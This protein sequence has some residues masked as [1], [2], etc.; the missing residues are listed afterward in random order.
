MTLN[1]FKEL[2]MLDITG[3][4]SGQQYSIILLTWLLKRVNNTKANLDLNTDT[5]NIHDILVPVL[6]HICLINTLKLNNEVTA[7]LKTEDVKKSGKLKIVYIEGRLYQDVVAF[8]LSDR[9]SL[10]E[11]RRC[12]LFVIIWQY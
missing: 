6:L 7:G 12:S 11:H 4:Q 5:G 2:N 3:D 1:P 9:R 8:E 10:T